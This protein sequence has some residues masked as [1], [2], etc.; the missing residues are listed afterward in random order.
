MLKLLYKNSSISESEESQEYLDEYIYFS[1][2]RNYDNFSEIYQNNVIFV[3]LNKISRMR[4]KMRVVIQKN[5]KKI[6]RN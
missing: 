1:Q 5:S 2:E 6:L 3:I 4:Y